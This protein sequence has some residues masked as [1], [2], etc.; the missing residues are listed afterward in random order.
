LVHGHGI[1]RLVEALEMDGPLVTVKAPALELDGKSMAPA[2]EGVPADGAK[3]GC[4]KAAVPARVTAAP[5]RIEATGRKTEAKSLVDAR[6][7]KGQEQGDIA[8]LAVDISD[9]DIT[10]TAIEDVLSLDAQR[11][12]ATQVMGRG[13]DLSSHREEQ[14]G[15]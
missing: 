11:N 14:I 6:A 4:A 3:I 1:R 7:S 12:L 8:A 5:C 10:D 13:H 9:H 2:T 15:A